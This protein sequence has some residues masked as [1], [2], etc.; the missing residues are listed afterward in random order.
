[1]AALESKYEDDTLIVCKLYQSARPFTQLIETVEQLEER[2][3][4]FH[5][6]S[7]V[8]VRGYG[9]QYEKFG[10]SNRI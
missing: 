2:R 3:I 7:G 5:P 6:H 1:M 4:D 10:Q 9:R 8:P